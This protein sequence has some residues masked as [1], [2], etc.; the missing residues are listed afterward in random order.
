M[1]AQDGII[2]GYVGDIGDQ[3]WICTELIAGTKYEFNLKGVSS[4]GGSL[5]D[6]LLKL[7]DDQGRLISQGLGVGDVVA[8]LDDSIVFRPTETGTYYL[9]LVMSLRFLKGLGH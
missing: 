6:P 8:G 9:A 2:H 7:Y 1:D 5:V 3:D 4:D